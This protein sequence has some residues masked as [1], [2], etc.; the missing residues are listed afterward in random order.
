MIKPK[1]IRQIEKDNFLNLYPEQYSLQSLKEKC[2]ALGIK[3]TI[4]YRD[5]YREYNLPSHPERLFKDDW[6][7][8]R[9][10]FDIPEFIS[11]QELEKKVRQQKLKNAKLML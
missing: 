10:F 7:S 1:A 8:Y 4:D 5:K 9:D 6:T 3:N 11:Y 2:K